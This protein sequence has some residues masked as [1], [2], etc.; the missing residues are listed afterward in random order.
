MSGDRYDHPTREDVLEALRETAR[1]G[2]PTV[3]AAQVGRRWFLGALYQHFRNF[4]AALV[5][6]GLAEPE[7]SVAGLR[8]LLDE[9]GITMAQLQRDLAV[10]KSVLVRLEGR[11]MARADLARRIA[12][13]LECSLDELATP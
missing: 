12:A 2:R 6:A 7:A 9:S 10:D 11:G 4:P 3:T 1:T 8:R 13:V 5:A